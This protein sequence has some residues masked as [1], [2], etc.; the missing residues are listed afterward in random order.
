MRKSD[1]F[2]QATTAI[3][4]KQVESARPLTA[5]ELKEISEAVITRKVQALPDPAQFLLDN[6]NFESPE[7]RAAIQGFILDFM[8]QDF[9]ADNG[10][11]LVRQYADDYEAAITELVETLKDKLL[12]CGDTGQ[13]MISVLDRALQ[14]PRSEI[15]TL[16]VCVAQTPAIVR[17]HLSVAERTQTDAI[18]KAFSDAM[19]AG[20]ADIAAAEAG[21]SLKAGSGPLKRYVASASTDDLG[22]EN[23]IRFVY[24]TVDN[25]LIFA[26]ECWDGNWG[27]I[28][29]ISPEELREWIVSNL[30][31]MTPERLEWSN[32]DDA[33]DWAMASFQIFGRGSDY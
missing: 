22:F 32:T 15:K 30:N 29:S 27:S 10:S 13:Q 12:L 18:V 7:R 6:F 2:E 23:D 4:S 20:L 33:P 17:R 28:D 21:V 16:A 1:I 24:D 8:K 3:K 5:A 9:R 25:A 19:R 11:L 26:Q 31:T 14:N